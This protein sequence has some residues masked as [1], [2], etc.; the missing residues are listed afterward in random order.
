VSDSPQKPWFRKLRY[1]IILGVLIALLLVSLVSYIPTGP[2]PRNQVALDNT[3]AYFASGYS[4]TTGLIPSTLNGST[5]VLYPDNYLVQLAVS[6]YD[7]GNQSTVS[8]AQAISAALG[9]YAATLPAGALQSEYT[10]L[11]STSSSFRCASNYTISW[12]SGNQS[13]GSSIAYVLKVTVN[14]GS[15]SC[16]SGNDAG[17]LLLQAILA[18][19]LGD[20]NATSI[21][22][23]AEKDFNG[24]GFTDESNSNTAASTRVYATSDVALFI[25]ATYCLDQQQAF[26]TDISTASSVLLHLQD[27]STGGFPATYTATSSVGPV[28][29][30]TTQATALAALALELM[31][32]PMGSC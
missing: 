17:V 27:N 9:G 30:E 13:I 28:S 32:N 7:P 21:Y 24:A 4:E 12:A 18:H 19:R 2:K 11:N 23:T 20:S 22:Q 3:I 25:Y 8:F 29:G 16:A 1:L 5:F 10:A 15:T 26:P 31:I 6:R 14:T